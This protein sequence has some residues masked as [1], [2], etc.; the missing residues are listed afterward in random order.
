MADHIIG[1]KMESSSSTA[2]TTT[3]SSESSAGFVLEQDLSEM[4]QIA[5]DLFVQMQIPDWQ[6]VEQAC[7]EM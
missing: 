2:T 3:S 4:I 1:G 5:K 6:K 7:Q